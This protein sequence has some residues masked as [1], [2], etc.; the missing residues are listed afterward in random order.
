MEI[1]SCA[2]KRRWKV[3][4]TAGR[5]LDQSWSQAVGGLLL[6]PRVGSPQKGWPSACSQGASRR[7]SQALWFLL[8]HILQVIWLLPA[9]V[10]S[11]PGAQVSVSMSL[12]WNRSA[13]EPESLPGHPGSWWVSRVFQRPCEQWTRWS[14]LEHKPCPLC[15]EFP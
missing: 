9:R 15:C 12:T 2:R 14:A 10:L 8:T 5:L 11:G 1:R 3:L 6:C 4:A 13:S 7:T